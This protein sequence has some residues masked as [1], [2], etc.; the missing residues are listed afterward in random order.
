[1]TSRLARRAIGVTVSIL[2]AAAALS[3]ASTRPATRVEVIRPP[4]EA[5]SA[6]PAAT[7]PGPLDVPLET[8]PLAPGAVIPQPIPPDEALPPIEPEATPDDTEELPAPTASRLVALVLP[9]DVPAYERAAS[10]VRDGFLDAAGAAGARG[11]CI[12]ISHGAD[13]VISA[14]E[15]ARAKGVRIAVG[16]LVRD[17]LKTLAISGAKLPWTLALNQLDDGARLP[18]AIFSF[19]LSVESDGRMLAQRALSTGARSV[20][21]I[22]GDS[23][24]MK[25][26]ASAFALAWSHQGGRVPDAY[27]FDPAPEA[28]TSLRRTLGQRVPDAVLLAVNGDRAAQ[29]KPFIGGIRAY[30]SGLVFER[31]SRAVARDL[32]G[33]RVVEI[34][35][36]LTP[37]APQFNGLPRRDFDSAALARLYALGIDAFRVAA[38]FESGPPARFELDGATGHVSLAPGRQFVREGSLAVYRDGELVPETSP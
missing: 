34:P 26:F 8:A 13:G 35:W 36:L 27:R 25:R 23:P 19:P 20:D 30:A 12:V 7:V 31:P 6:P 3:C 22:E 11:D 10:A 38:S 17:D 15:T 2:F 9:L 28:L 18:G 21:V 16:P 5:R 1:M 4:A 33:V 37:D 24:L 32:D 14:F 29:V